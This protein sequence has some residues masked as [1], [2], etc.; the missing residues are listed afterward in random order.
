MKIHCAEKSI[1]GQSTPVTELPGGAPLRRG[2]K[3]RSGTFEPRLSQSSKFFF[4]HM[5]YC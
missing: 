4:W 2:E 1:E 5:I 3:V